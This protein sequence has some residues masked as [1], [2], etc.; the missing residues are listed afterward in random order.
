[1]IT[2]DLRHA[3]KALSRRPGLS[4][5]VVMILALGIGSTTTIFSIA[6][7]VLLRKLPYRDGDRLVVIKAH[8]EDGSPT[9]ASYLDVQS[10]RQQS[11]TLELIS[12]NSNYQQ[13]NL[14]GGDRAE[15]V[16]VGFASASYFDLLGAGPALGRVFQP[17]DENRTS[18]VSVTV[19]S[20]NLWQRRFGGDPAIVGRAIQ[21]QGLTFH[22][23]GI[24]P[25]GF[26]DVYQDIDV[27]LP[28]TAARLTHREGYVEDRMVRW[29]AVF[30]RLRPGAGIEQAQQEMRSISQQLAVTFPKTN[31]G[32]VATVHPFR[33]YQFDFDRMRLSILT[34][35]IGAAFVLLI[36]C[37]NVTNLL[38]VRAVERRKEVALRLALGGTRF[39]LIRQFVLE[40]AILC[41]A[42]AVLGVGAAFFAVGL[43]D[44][45]GNFAYN[46]PDFLHFAVD[47]RA[48]TAA[49]ALSILISLLNGVIPARESLKVNLQE[50]LQ[51]E[52]K[53]H[54]HSAGTA[55]TRSVL[56]V[57]AVFFSVVLLT[58][59]GLVIKSLQALMQ[60]DPGFRVDHILSARFELPTTQYRANEPVYQLYKQV[61][62]KARSLPDVGDAGLWAPGMLGSSIYLQFIVPEG[63]SPEAPGEQIRIYE[64]RITP[65]LLRKVGIKLLAGRE[66]TEQ[67]DARHPRIAVLSRSTAAALWPS[68]D[69][70]G[71]RFW[72]G[73]PHSVWVQVVGVAADADQRGRLLP[74]HDFR[75][76]VY[77]P[78]F[79]MRSRT[80]SIL[81][82]MRREGGK[83]R[84]QLSQIMQ[85][86][87]PDIPVYDVQT[88]QEQRR[89]EEAGVRLNAWLLIFFAS[90]ALVL[91]VI[92]IYS[93]LIYTVRQQ[94]FE[95]GIRV[96]LGADQSD[97]LRHFVWKGVAL[98]GSGLI[99]GLAGALGLAKGMSSILF[100]VNPHDPLVFVAVPCIIAVL[101]LPAILRPAYRATRAAPSSLFRLR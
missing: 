72:L 45:V 54:S 64:H 22:V 76:D 63:H 55:F 65:D 91:A 75:R 26:R 20:H 16:G 12:V 29:L 59:A 44:K 89:S 7:S 50:E 77:F 82:L 73:A 78:L 34:T 61:V 24:L 4:L 42:G 36:G 92:G 5:A 62:D 17:E 49:V 8:E 46:L 60:S 83:T 99:A 71:K 93:I 58:G 15:R 41:V 56:V 37:T 85:T 48:L 98:L 96:A 70:I 51:L 13:L 86:I 84:E 68:Q 66:F 94:R 1:M 87:A 28:V 100:D 38:L 53:G 90:S 69:P 32:Y 79:Q 101:A 74:Y 2:H 21:I 11:R 97:I 43:L 6:S 39:R 57:S 3:L 23:V 19:L 10:W 9:A 31:H 95:L 47:L 52:G 25:A 81:L 33:T 30:A 18:P 14:T 80:T 88:V 67:D 40:G 27:Y 35:L